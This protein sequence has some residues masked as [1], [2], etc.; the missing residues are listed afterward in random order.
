MG[1]GDGYPGESEEGHAVVWEGHPRTR[2]A[3][4]VRSWLAKG[5]RPTQEV[6]AISKLGWPHTAIDCF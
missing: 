2:P 4:L 1:M 3:G 5:A 6:L